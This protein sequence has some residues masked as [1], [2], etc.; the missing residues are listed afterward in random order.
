VTASLAEAAET[1]KAKMK[2]PI[3][4]NQQTLNQ[5]HPN[6]SMI[7]TVLEATAVTRKSQAWMGSVWS[8][9]KMSNRIN[10]R[11]NKQK[12]SKRRRLKRALQGANMILTAWEAIAATKKFQDSMASV[13]SAERSQR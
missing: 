7:L 9:V 6:A 3:K 12:K 5:P 1:E 13:W 10:N 11:Q 4:K 2:L 8:V